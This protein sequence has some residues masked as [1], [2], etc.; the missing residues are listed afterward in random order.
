M[1]W[2]KPI[3]RFK[4]FFV[5]LFSRL[6]VDH[7]LSRQVILRSFRT[8]RRCVESSLVQFQSGLD[9]HRLGLGP[10]QSFL[11]VQSTTESTID[12]QKTS[13]SSSTTNQ[14]FFSV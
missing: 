13:S 1:L 10:L 6:S 11:H 2:M 7:S 3:D 12:P 14:T 5:H 8:Y 4:R 9:E